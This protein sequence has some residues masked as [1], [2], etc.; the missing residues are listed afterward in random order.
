M[1]TLKRSQLFTCIDKRDL[2]ALAFSRC[3]TVHNAKFMKQRHEYEDTRLHVS[4]P[5]TWTLFSPR[6]HV[7]C[8]K[9]ITIIAT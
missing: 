6:K 5:A 8:C 3:K 9:I 1:D 4:Q 2:V 7:A